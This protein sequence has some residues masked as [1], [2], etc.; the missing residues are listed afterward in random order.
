MTSSEDASQCGLPAERKLFVSTMLLIASTV[1]STMQHPPNM[2]P[3]GVSRRSF[4]KA[5]SALAAGAPLLAGL[6]QAQSREARGSLIDYVRLEE[7][8]VGGECRS[9]WS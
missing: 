9:P 5:S 7:R 3:P 6:L 2:I 8:R 1:R 4:L